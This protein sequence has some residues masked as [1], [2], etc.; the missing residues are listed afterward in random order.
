MKGKNDGIKNENEIVEAFNGK[1]IKELSE[2]HKKFLE[3]LDSEISDETVVHAK[4][5]GGQ[6]FK[7]DVEIELNNR[8]WNVSVKKGSGNSVHQEKTEYFIYYC[9]KFLDM[10]EKEKN[11]LLLYLYGDGTIDGDSDVDD[12]LSDDEL[13]EAYSSEIKD[14]QKFLDRNKKAL[15]ERFLVFG[16]L[17]KQKNIS[18]DYM[19][20]G[21][22]VTGVW[23]P[24]DNYSIEH[25]ANSYVNDGKLS[26]GPLSLQVWNRNL[27]GKKNLEDRRH[28]IQ[29][30]WASCHTCI[31]SMNAKYLHEYNNKIETQQR[32]MGDNKQGFENQNKLVILLDGQRV[33]KLEPALK[34]II[35][36][37]FP[38]ANNQEVITCSSLKENDIKPRIIINLGDKCAYLSVFMGSGNSV[39]QENIKTFLP[40]CEEELKMTSD[41]K[42]AFLQILYGDGTIDG[43][44][45]SKDRLNDAQIK[46][47]YTK[48]ISI[49]QGFLNNNKR[50]LVERFLV[51]GKSG[52][53]K[54]IKSDYIY[55]GTEATGR[56]I[57]SSDAVDHI[58]D[59]KAS[60]SAVLSIGSLTIQTWNRNLNKKIEKEKKRNSIQVKWGSIKKNLQEIRNYIDVNQKGTID[61]D[62]EEYELVAKLNRNRCL[63]SK[64]WK[65][66]AEKLDLADIKDIYAIKVCKTVYSSLAERNVLPKAD[67]FL[68]KGHIP[69]SRLIE[70]NYWLDEDVIKNLKVKIVPKSGISCKRPDSKSFTYAKL[71]M[72]SFMKLTEDCNLGA[73]IGLFV[74]ECDMKYNTTLVQDWGTCEESI[75]EY[76]KDVLNELDFER[77]ERTLN[78][79]EVCKKIKRE[80]IGRFSELIRTNKKISNSI[81]NGIGVFPEPYAAYFV[82][83]NSEIVSN[84]IPKFSIT[85]GSGRHNR[86]YTIIIKP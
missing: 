2:I 76:Y 69:H 12:R 59:Q 38:E 5:V 22:A 7:P 31:E 48:Q 18:A 80:S 78:N 51:Y 49:V 13:V 52:L 53:D 10:T 37:I 58:V 61:G 72:K 60:T 17:G 42:D 75:I 46:R 47:E 44:S 9:M 19:Y 83:I 56:L 43:N 70:N 1:R 28:S 6:G 79:I 23:C 24:L 68:V 4:K 62:W 85:T 36:E 14:V 40:Y 73:G 63:E 34:S 71:S 45:E 29:I 15:L 54:N 86:K 32:I 25:L 30:K 35:K 67:I 41:E 3:Q 11:S 65:E 21:N 77:E 64:I 39:H 57:S 20:H 74:T 27:L 26:I 33:D 66:I 82:Y 84:N 81:F 16:R 8:I 50:A 55:Y